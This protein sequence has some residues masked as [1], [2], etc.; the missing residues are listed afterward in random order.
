MTLLKLTDVC[1]E[2]DLVKY[3]L[4]KNLEFLILLYHHFEYASLTC[5]C[6]CV[7][8]T[9]ISTINYNQTYMFRERDIK[10]EDN[11]TLTSNKDCHYICNKQ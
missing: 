6:V 1:N 4:L 10:Y 8:V 2:I 7:H 5:M 9:F 3:I 11:N